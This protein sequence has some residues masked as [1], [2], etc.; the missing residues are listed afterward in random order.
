MLKLSKPV[1]RTLTIIA[2]LLFA[3]SAYYF[4][5]QPKPDDLEEAGL[6]MLAGG[7]TLWAALYFDARVPRLTDEET[8]PFPPVERQPGKGEKSNW[9]LFCLGIF[10]IVLLTEINANTLNI[11]PPVS[12]HLQFLM[13][14]AAIVCVVLGLGGVGARRKARRKKPKKAVLNHQSAPP[15]VLILLALITLLAFG[16]RAWQAGGL[17]HKFVDEVHFST[18]VIGAYNGIDLKL[19]AP[20]STITAFPWIYPY[21]QTQTVHLLGRELEGLR[22]VSVILGTLGIPALYLLART[23]FDRPTAL[24][25]ALLLAVFPPHIHFSR[26][27]LNNIADP[28]FG[29]LALAFLLRGLK[30][31]RRLDFALGG[32]ALGL[33]QYFYEGGRFL[34]PAL[35]CIGLAWLLLTRRRIPASKVQGAGLISGRTSHTELIIFFLTALLIALPVYITLVALDQPLDARFQTVGIG[36]SYWLKVNEF[37]QPQTLEQHLVLPFLVYVHLPELA[38]YYGGEQAMLLPLVVPF[39]L[40]GAFALAPRLRSP[41]ILI[42]LWILLTSA[43]NMLLTEAGVYAR[44]VVAFPAL[45]LLVAAGIRE[46]LRLLWPPHFPADHVAELMTIIGLGLAVAQV[47]YYFGPHLERYNQQ[48]R[49]VYDA[50]DAIFRSARFPPNTQVHIFTTET[51]GGAY[52]SGVAGYLSDGLTVFPI[53]PDDLTLTYLSSLPRGIDHAFYLEPGD[54][55]TLALVKTFYD[56]E[57]PFFSPYRVPADRQLALYYFKGIPAG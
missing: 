48:I 39:F 42:L 43:G 1:A 25:A 5:Y 21:W 35:I 50:E 2:L 31:G 18:A 13:L 41:I 28:L 23:L 36:G 6:L 49:L 53:H 44:Y 14:V 17:V 46:A 47:A 55:S 57:G 24:L 12:A 19:L 29:T 45:M 38:L 16:L 4:R 37:G 15:V 26:I 7:L 56:V 34:Y 52:L 51:P 32:A 22:A 30:N 8:L 40:F 27:G 11:L 33:T 9:L 54:A 10:I 3:L 20:F